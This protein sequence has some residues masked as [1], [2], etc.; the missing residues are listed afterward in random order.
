[1]TLVCV[2]AICR[3]RRSF[4]DTHLSKCTLQDLVWQMLLLYKTPPSTGAAS[5]AAPALCFAQT[6]VQ[7]RAA[8][9]RIGALLTFC[10]QIWEKFN[11]L[12]NVSGPT[13]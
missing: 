3:I 6:E 10:G 1:M 7:H 9:G 8:Q 5:A 4:A 11:A 12:I 13:S 2:A